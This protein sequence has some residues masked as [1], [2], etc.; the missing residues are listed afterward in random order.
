MRTVNDRIS[1]L[2]DALGIKQKDFAQRINLKPNTLSMIKN[3][4]R[5]VT[6]RVLDDICREFNVS[7]KWLIS[8][9]GEMYNKRTE[10]FI[11][12]LI[13]QY[14]LTPKDRQI[15]ESYVTMPEESR[16]LFYN[17]IKAFSGRDDNTE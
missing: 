6:D 17:F 7:K 14:Q 4:K 3:K 1:I 9:E 11:D 8:G 15:L 10:D 16:A 5:N 12:R 2:I 13:K